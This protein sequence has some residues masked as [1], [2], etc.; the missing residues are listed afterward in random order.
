MLLGFLVAAVD[1]FEEISLMLLAMHLNRCG[2][3]AQWG[4]WTTGHWSWHWTYWIK[5]PSSLEEAL[6]GGPWAVLGLAPLPEAAQ[7]PA[8]IEPRT[9]MESYCAEKRTGQFTLA[10][11][12]SRAGCK[13][14]W[15]KAG[16]IAGL[17]VG[18]ALTTWEPT[19]LPAIW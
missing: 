3:S 13:K 16:A 4:Y 11:M 2:S 18:R 19:F 8:K 5:S 9:A 1:L 15:T 14:G 7:E 6:I 17:G 12:C 10:S